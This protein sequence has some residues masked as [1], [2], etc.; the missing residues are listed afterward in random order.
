MVSRSSLVE[1]ARLLLAVLV[2]AMG[3]TFIAPAMAWHLAGAGAD[4]DELCVS[5]MSADA[6][7]GQTG[8]HP[9]HSHASCALCNLATHMA[10]PPASPAAVCGLADVPPA[11]SVESACRHLDVVRQQARAPPR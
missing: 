4:V 9:S 8:A 1:T 11:D 3:V 5:A 10:P 7:V 2:L 6:D